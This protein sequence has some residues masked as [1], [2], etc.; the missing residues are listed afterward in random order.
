MSAPNESWQTI[1]GSIEQHCLF[2]GILSCYVGAAGKLGPGGT[3]RPG[4]DH[5]WSIWMFG[6]LLG[7]GFTDS[8]SSARSACE[9]E[10]DRV[11]WK[12][13]DAVKGMD[14]RRRDTG[15]FQND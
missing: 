9:Q 6:A 3:Y 15:R 4:F 10:A 7:E 1:P 2:N 5:R 11:E 8:E 14:I 12:I 13:R